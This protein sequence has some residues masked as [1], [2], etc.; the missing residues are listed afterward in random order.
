MTFSENGPNSSFSHN[1]MDGS[2]SPIGRGF[3]VKV[4]K[5]IYIVGFPPRLQGEGIQPTFP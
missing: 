3:R 4:I 5:S 1:A 2:S